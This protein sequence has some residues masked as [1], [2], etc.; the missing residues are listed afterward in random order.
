MSQHNSLV[1]VVS[2]A[3]GKGSGEAPRDDAKDVTAGAQSLEQ[4]VAAMNAM[5]SVG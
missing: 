4:A 2:A 3:L 1:E 5:L